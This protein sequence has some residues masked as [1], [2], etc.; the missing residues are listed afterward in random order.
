MKAQELDE[1]NH[2]KY[3]IVETLFY[4]NM[5]V[6][7]YS[8][9]GNV[10]KHFLDKG[11]RVV[12]E[13]KR[14][15]PDELFGNPCLGIYCNISPSTGLFSK[16]KVEIEMKDCNGKVLYSDMGKGV[17]ET[18]TEAYQNATERALAAF[19][20]LVYQYEPGNTIQLEEQL[21]RNRIEGLYDAI[22]GSSALKIEISVKDGKIEARIVYSSDKKYQNGQL[23]ASFTESSLSNNLYNVEWMPDDKD[24]Y[25][26]LASLENEGGRLT[27][28]LKEENEKKQLVFRKIE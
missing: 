16:Y 10:R 24:S 11:I 27:I 9:S 26:T 6:D 13:S 3:A 8:I 2:F 23:L 14:Y 25:I 17:G 28:E 18:G 4:E 21:T 5:A 12:S 19:D 20:D 15:W 22:G 7:I 1:L